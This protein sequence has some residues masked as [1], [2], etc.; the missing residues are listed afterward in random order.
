VWT[1]LDDGTCFLKNG[2]V[3][4]ERAVPLNDSPGSVCGVVPNVEGQNWNFFCDFPGN[5]IGQANVRGED[6]GGLCRKTANCTHF[7][8]NQDKGGTCFFKRGVKTMDDSFPV[9]DPGS[10]CGIIPEKMAVP[11]PKISWKN[12]PNSARVCDFPGKDLKNVTTE[13]DQC[14]NR[15]SATVNCT[16]YSW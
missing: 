9:D 13:I 4:K 10:V 15:C 7:F 1:A 16:H 12:T 8:W 2:N 3:S 11:K 5:D 6:C 14:F